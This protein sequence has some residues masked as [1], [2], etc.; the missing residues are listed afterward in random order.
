MNRQKVNIRPAPGSIRLMS[1]ARLV[2]RGWYRSSSMQRTIGQRRW[3]TRWWRVC[4]PAGL[5]QASLPRPNRWKRSPSGIAI[6]TT[7]ILPMILQVFYP[8]SAPPVW[9]AWQ[10]QRPGRGKLWLI[11][12]CSH[13]SVLKVDV[14]RPRNRSG[15]E[16]GHIHRL[17]AVK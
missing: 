17:S 11:S 1:R 5:P 2:R 14:Q 13:R 12:S 7:A 10:M 4:A 16:P 9:L 15:R 6:W 3:R 8:V